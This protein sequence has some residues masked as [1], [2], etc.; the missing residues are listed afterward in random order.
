MLEVH[1]A[2]YA[3]LAANEAEKAAP[4]HLLE[5]ITFGA[6]GR[7]WLGG[8]EAEIAEA[9]RAIQ[10]TAR[11]HRRPREQGLAA[12]RLARARYINE[13][14]DERRKEPRVPMRAE[15]EVRVHLVARLLAHLHDQHLEGRHE[16]R[17]RRGAEGG[18]RAHRQAHAARRHRPS[19]SRRPSRHTVR[20]SARRW[21]DRCVQFRES[22]RQPNGRRSKRPSARHGGHARRRPA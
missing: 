7:L 20:R 4:I 15:A 8:C 18:R 21:S 1:P 6:V 11:G 2:A 19:C 3:A 17:A 13:M 14:S 9:A 5:V 10:E 12:G 16:P 22:R